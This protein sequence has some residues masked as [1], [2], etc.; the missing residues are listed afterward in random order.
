MYLFLNNNY[1]LSLDDVYRIE[2]F[3]VMCCTFIEKI[4]TMYIHL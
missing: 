2:D 3:I 4:D 1:N